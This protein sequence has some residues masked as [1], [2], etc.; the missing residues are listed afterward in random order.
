MNIYEA[1]FCRRSTRKYVM[2]PLDPEYLE[3][4]RSVIE[5][6]SP[7]DSSSR[8]EME[9]VE[10]LDKKSKV[11]GLMKADAPYYLAV[12]CED[13]PMAYRSAGYAAEQV[14]LYM[15][16]K[17]IGTCYLG[18]AKIGEKEKNGLKQLLV[19]SFG[20]ADGPVH[21]EMEDAHR[22]P[23]SG[24]CTYKDEP[25]ENLKKILKAARMAPSSMNTQPWRFVVYADRIYVFARK[26][27]FP[28]PKMF[29]AM[30]DFNIGIMLSHIMLSAEELWMDMETETEELYARKNY[31][32]GDY[33]CTIFFNS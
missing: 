10:N 30:R 8:V 5:M 27:S 11:K 9:I 28:H 29:G 32:N 23:L 33:I 17:G 26:E 7:L 20:R 12:Y 22:L 3:A 21:R 14:V 16:S 18:S 4:F 1:I 13:T 31:K 24:L 2:E 15:T 19:I 6:V 25:G